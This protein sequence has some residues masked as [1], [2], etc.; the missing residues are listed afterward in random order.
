MEKQHCKLQT[1]LH[2]QTI[3]WYTLVHK[4]QKIGPRA[5]HCHTHCIATHLVALNGFYVMSYIS[6]VWSVVQVKFLCS[7]FP[8]VNIQVD[9]GVGPDNIET[10]AE[11]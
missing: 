5:G 2:R 6:V 4:W 9:G 10:C 1:I 7:R 11:V 3:I 8:N